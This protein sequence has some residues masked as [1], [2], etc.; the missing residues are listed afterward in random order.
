MLK[1]IL[2]YIPEFIVVS[3]AMFWFLENYLDSGIVNYYALFAAFLISVAALSKMRSLGM[4]MGAL[5]IL[6]ALFMGYRF[7]VLYSE[8]TNPSTANRLLIVFMSV[9]TVSLITGVVLFF[10]YFK[11]QRR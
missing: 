10:K 5:T 9:F 3:I 7:V 8:I 2:W 11:S 4:L 1:K 6:F